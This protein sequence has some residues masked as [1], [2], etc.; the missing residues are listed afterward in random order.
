M[1]DILKLRVEQPT[2]EVDEIANQVYKQSKIE[3]FKDLVN[4]FTVRH[5]NEIIDW[6]KEVEEF[7]GN[8]VQYYVNI[9]GNLVPVVHGGDWVKI[10][11]FTEL[12]D[13]YITLKNKEISN[14]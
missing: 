7:D 5:Q 3:D 13:A 6:T 14:D 1:I 9:C 4:P 11:D 8:K 12:L 10:E 2:P